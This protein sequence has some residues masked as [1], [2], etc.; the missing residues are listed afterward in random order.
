MAE[1]G[2]SGYGVGFGQGG[3]DDGSLGDMPQRPGGNA[4]TKQ[5]RSH[6]KSRNGCIECK[7]RHMRCDEARPACNNCSMAERACVYPTQQDHSLQRQQQQQQ[8][9]PRQHRQQQYQQ[10]YLYPQQPPQ[11]Q[12]QQPSPAESMSS[13]TLSSSHGYTTTPGQIS[14]DELPRQAPGLQSLPSFNESFANTPASP[15]APASSFTAQHLVLLHHA[16]TAMENDFLGDGQNRGIIDISIRNAVETPYLI[17]QMLAFAAMHMAH[18]QPESAAR[19]RHQATELQTRALSYFTKEADTLEPESNIHPAQRFL[20]ATLLGLHVLAETLPCMR[21]DFQEFIHRFIRCIHLHKGIRSVSKPQWESLLK[22]EILPIL[23]LATLRYPSEP[24]HGNECE[25]LNALMDASDLDASSVGACR[26]A[27][28]TLQWSFDL[29]A[30]LPHQELPHAVT[31]F[32]AIVSAEFGEVLKKHRAEALI[33]LAYYGVL[34]HRAR[35]YWIF[36]DAGVFLI[37]HIAS[38]LGD[39]WQEHMRW[40]LETLEQDHD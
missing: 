9:Q 38:V 25:P 11:P 18:K 17:D 16:E 19:Y 36:G 26:A 12:Q 31:G 32:S 10:Q 20:F 6:R 27:V 33:I 13:S 23:E 24:V 37:R 22:S 3:D 8:Q 14:S 1:A 5:R 35:K 30:R 34:L 7:R 2:G 21:S 40:P 28:Q 15:S 39:F 4:A 29:S